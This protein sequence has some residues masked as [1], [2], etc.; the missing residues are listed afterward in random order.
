MAISEKAT[1]LS[2][3]S[4]GENVTVLPGAII[5]RIPL[6][7]GATTRQIDVSQLS[8]TEIGDDCVVGA[9]CVIYAGVTIG[10]KTM[11]GDTACIRE[12]CQI[13]GSCVIAMGVTINYNTRVGDRVKVMDNT[14]LT[15]NM[16]I[17]DDVFIGPLVATANDQNMGRF[18]KSGAKKWLEG[19][20]LIRRFAAIGQGACLLPGVE[21][22]ENAIV[23][24]G[25]VV[26]KDVKPRTVVMGVP[27]RFV[28]NLR[29]EEVRIQS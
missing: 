28:R 1:I 13:G 21:I 24:T 27:A 25:A 14:H 11:I 16:V 4:W 20:P 15:G 17:E 9:N 10:V 2:P 6:F 23:G 7:S 22:G 8:P 19:G 26:T 18:L 12:G 29:P 3:V 5:G